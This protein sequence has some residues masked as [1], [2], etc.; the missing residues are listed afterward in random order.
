LISIFI[1]SC[2][3]DP[4]SCNRDGEIIG[5]V[6]TDLDLSDSFIRSEEA[7]IG[8]YIA[9]AVL[10][11]INNDDL[12]I[13]R[14][15]EKF[16]VGDNFKVDFAIINGGAIRHC[17][18]NAMIKKGSD[19]TTGMIDELLPFPSN[20]YVVKITG[21]ELIEIFEH[22]VAKVEEK[23]GQ[24][25]QVSRE[26]KVIYDKSKKPEILNKVGEKEYEVTFKGERVKELYIDDARVDVAKDYYVATSG[27]LVTGGDQFVTFSLISDDKKIEI[28]KTYNEA[29]SDYIMSHSTIEPKIEGRIVYVSE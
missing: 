2:I 3:P 14:L 4:I 6:T 1:T 16:G 20:I 18:S 13:S 10:D 24:F 8:N 11:F 17:S 27:Y 7:P 22:S 12:S 25:L 9:D 21:G 29:L 28:N 15:K 23:K 26:I 19:F 5:I